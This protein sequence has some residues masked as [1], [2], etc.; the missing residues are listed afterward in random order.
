[1]SAER[2][3]PMRDLAEYAADCRWDELAA[4]ADFMTIDRQML[5][6]LHTRARVALALLDA[7]TPAG[8]PS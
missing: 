5:R 7:T 2:A 8:D 4:G 3:N 6:E 1:M